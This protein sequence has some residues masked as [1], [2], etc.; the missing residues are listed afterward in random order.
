MT[1]ALILATA[2]A[3]DG[4]AAALLPLGGETPL[5][6]LLAQLRRRGITDATVHTRPQWDAAVRALVANTNIAVSTEPLG[7]LLASVDP[8]AHL[9]VA[10]GHGVGH[11]AVVE[12]IVRDRD[13]VALVDSSG[14]AL[15]LLAVAP[16]DR[17]ALAGDAPA[18]AGTATLQSLHARLAA[19]TLMRSV[20]TGPLAWLL[21]TGT[22]QAA[23]A[24]QATATPSETVMLAASVKKDDAFFPTFF[25]SPYSR[26]IA[27][28]AAHRGVTPNQATVVS[29]ALGLAVAPCFALGTRAGLVA[30]AVLLQVSY[31]ADTV[32]GQ[33]ARYARRSSAFGAWLD[34]TFD[35]LKEYVVY[36]GL[37]IGGVRAGGEDSIWVLAAAA[38]AL[39]TV[40]HMAVFGYEEAKAPQPPRAKVADAGMRVLGRAD[41]V[42]M[43]RW[44]KRILVL[45]IGERFA[46]IS[47][48]AAVATPRTTFAWLLAWGGVAAA[49]MITG[50]LLRS[51]AAV[52]RRALYR[53][54][55][56]LAQ[57]LRRF[58][59]RDAAPR[60]GGAR[61]GWLEPALLR[62]AEYSLLVW[63]SWRAGGAALPVVFVLLVVVAFHHYDLFHRTW[64]QQPP[65]P[66]VNA[67]GLGW[68]GRMV[69]MVAAW[70]V[71][72]VVPAAAAL[73][74]L[75]T[76]VFVSESVLSWRGSRA[77]QRGVG[78][79]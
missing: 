30:G 54:D 27:R 8:G 26:Y 21:P 29:L 18:D 60:P 72:V 33:I 3:D 55:G 24:Q 62:T 39:Q 57:A 63:L 36:A 13:T 15:G 53:D 16:A 77:V 79:R 2:A 4:T 59:P 22:A 44:A 70:A 67:A 78:G 74:A 64:Y 40:R 7:D 76:V 1:V 41:R 52:K 48:T 37:A 51:T 56:P 28:W 43:L 25:V 58:L 5:Q 12:W 50:R 73:A 61:L 20:D 23:A 38:L 68:D 10:D 19:A 71:G 35:R 46:L 65:P 69:V 6:R 75:C 47:I 32:D 34:S 14:V 49:Y 45:P 31:L 11:D 42:P 17:P 9:L 66:W